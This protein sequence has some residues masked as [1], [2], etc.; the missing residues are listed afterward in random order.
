MLEEVLVDVAPEALLEGARAWHPVHGIRELVRVASLH[1]D[2]AWAQQGDASGKL[3]GCK[4][5]LGEWLS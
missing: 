3:G 5:K 2:R 4:L 1:R